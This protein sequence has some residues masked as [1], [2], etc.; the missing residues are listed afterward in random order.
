VIRWFVKMNAT[1]ALL[2]PAVERNEPIDKRT[3]VFE[4]EMIAAM[5]NTTGFPAGLQSY[6]N[7]QVSIF[8]LK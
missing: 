3:L 4:A 1:A 5:L 6:P 7:V 2:Q 8:L